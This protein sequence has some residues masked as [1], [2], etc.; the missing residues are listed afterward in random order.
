MIRL[1]GHNNFMRGAADAVNPLNHPL[2]KVRAT[3]DDMLG[4]ATGTGSEVVVHEWSYAAAKALR[5]AGWRPGRQVDTTRW[6][7]QFAAGGVV[8]HPAAE[9]FLAE[10]G[11]LRFRGGWWWV[12]SAAEVVDLDPELCADEGDRFL[13]WSRELGISLFPVGRAEGIYP[14]GIDQDGVIYLVATWVARFGALDE[15]VEALVR[16]DLPKNVA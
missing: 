3:S 16:G 4:S 1:Q 15:G 5:K 11:G 9:R 14:L 7:E 6:R 8:M 13:H 2:F 12:L 10:F